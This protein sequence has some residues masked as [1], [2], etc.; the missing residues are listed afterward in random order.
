MVPRI[1]IILFVIMFFFT[2]IGCNTGHE[3][4]C[5]I[6]SFFDPIEIKEGEE[7]TIYG[8]LTSDD[9][10]DEHSVPSIC[11]VGCS[12]NSDVPKV[13]RIHLINFPSHIYS[14]T[15]HYVPFIVGVRGEVSQ[16]QEL[17]VKE[18]VYMRS[19]IDMKLTVDKHWKNHSQELLEETG[20]T[21]VDGAVCREPLFNHNTD[22]VV[23]CH[24]VGEM[25]VSNDFGDKSYE[26]N[27]LVHYF[28][29][30]DDN[31]ITRIHY[32][33]PVFTPEVELVE[34]HP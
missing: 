10:S 3:D 30:I 9:I 27:V 14:P 21:M 5:N 20:S 11:Y 4:E 2:L 32:C 34:F 17:K 31:N 19:Y 13:C 8:Y 22:E 26:T 12:T 15:Q 33:P 28:V 23:F 29:N 6:L 1:T 18:V 24:D 25:K 16:A 7:A